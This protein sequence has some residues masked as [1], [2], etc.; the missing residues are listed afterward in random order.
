MRTRTRTCL[1]VALTLGCLLT[2]AC[3]S[4][5]PS[6]SSS[7]GTASGAFPATV[8]SCDE[9]LT[10][11]KSPEKVL[12]MDDTDLS[13]LAEMNLLDRIVGRSG[14]LR[15]APYDENTLARIKKIPE[16]ASS[17]LDSGGTQVATETVIASG[18]DLVI[19]FDAGI[20]RDALRKAGIPVYA[21]V[22]FCPNLNPAKATFGMVN[23]EIAKV[24]SIFGAPEKG[25]E[26]T[27]RMNAKISGLTKE[28]R[29]RGS[30]AVLYV[31]PGSK[32]FYVYGKSSMVQP[33][34]EANGFTNVYGEDPQRVFDGSME[35]LLAKNPDH[36]VL[37]Y[38]EGKSEEAEPTLMT[39]QGAEKL[40]AV[41]NKKVIT[42]AYS[43]TD[44][45]TPNSVKGATVLDGL[46]R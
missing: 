19:G 23:D 8:N 28:G 27:E 42:M 41:A 46:V 34:V 39:F 7:G 2:T 36:L 22:S 1:T 9:K 17:V 4:S 37:L 20:D 3:S 24:A 11:T 13:I 32:S 40:S 45:P 31:M 14:K 12:I 30:V 18:A 43:L 33:I 5:I 25:R 15:T 6:N 10:F 21:P 29:K 44:P 35:D 26:L 38:G 16:I